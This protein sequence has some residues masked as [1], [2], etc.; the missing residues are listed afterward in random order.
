[1]EIVLEVPEQEQCLRVKQVLLGDSVKVQVALEAWLVDMGLTR[2]RY[3]SR[4][5]NI[6]SE[7]DSLFMWLLAQCLGIHINLIHANGIWSTRHSGVPNLCDPAIMFILG[8]YLAV[9]TIQQNK[10]GTDDVAGKVLDKALLAKFAVPEDVL[11]HFV[12]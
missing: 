9:P 10:E 11:E 2:P 1:M 7:P 5:L 8:H 3:L 4:I 12:P 6:C